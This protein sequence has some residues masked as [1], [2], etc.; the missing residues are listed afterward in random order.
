MQTIPSM[1]RIVRGRTE[2]IVPHQNTELA[3]ISPAVGPDNY[4]SVG[5]AIIQ[6]GLSVPHGDYTAPLVHAAYCSALK[7]EPEFANVRDMA[8]KRWLWVFNRNLWTPQGVYTIQDERAVGRSEPL[9]VESLEGML[10]G[11]RE[12]KTG[13]IRFSQDSRVRFAPKGSYVFGERSA[14]DL[15]K[16]GFMITQYGERGAELLAEAS[17]TLRNVPITYGLDI[18]EGQ[19]PELHFSTLG[20]LD[21]RLH[22]VGNYLDSYG[23][24]C[25]FSVSAP[26][27]KI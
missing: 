9:T 11:G 18:A 7:D 5:Q 15:A 3:Y 22:F 26:S 8:R 12:L 1:P 20:E 25:A 13:G 4:Q 14:N 10:K 21:A 24:C 19:T 6:Q 16:D 2:M 23:H 27:V 17:A